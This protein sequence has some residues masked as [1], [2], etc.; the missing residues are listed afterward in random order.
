MEGIPLKKV[1]ICHFDPNLC[2]ICQK[3]KKQ[4]P[5]STDNGRKKVSNA[6]NL[7]KG[8]VYH[9]LTEYSGK[10]VYHVNYG[11]YKRYVHFEEPVDVPSC[12][13]DG[14]ETESPDISSPLSSPQT[15]SHSTP[16]DPCTPQVDIKVFA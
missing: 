10:F 9:R 3:K 13:T 15:R 5:S 7:K 2:V 11:C 6:A 14:T 16:R 4:K 8:D 12:S 1:N